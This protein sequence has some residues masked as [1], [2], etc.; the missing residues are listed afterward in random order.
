MSGTV[1]GND[2]AEVLRLF[3]AP[4]ALPETKSK[5]RRDIGATYDATEL[6]C[7]VIG[8]ASVDDVEF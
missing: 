2:L 3:V 5:A 4:A 6:A 8:I 7:D 1:F